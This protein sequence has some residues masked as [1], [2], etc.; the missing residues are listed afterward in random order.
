[1]RGSDV[2]QAAMLSYQTLEERIPRGHSLRKLRVL[3]DGILVT[4]CTYYL[5]E[6]RD[7][8]SPS[9][10]HWRGGALFFLGER[11]RGG[12]PPKEFRRAG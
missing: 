1:M 10:L 11:R 9:S 7:N 6:M 4:R 2:T 3:V 5:W 8:L 12:T